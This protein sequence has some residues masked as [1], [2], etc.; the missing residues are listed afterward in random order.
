MRRTAAAA[1]LASLLTGMSDPAVCAHAQTAVPFQ[2]VESAPTPARS[3][4]LGNATVLAGLV[5][6][7]ASFP[8]ATQS[9]RRYEE[10]LAESDPTA[11]ES[12]WGAAQR[13]DR[14]ATTSLLAGEALLAAGVYLRFL[15]RSPDS[16]LRFAASASRCAVTLRF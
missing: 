10:Y 9:D 2:P 12:R 7:G 1:L 13:A 16:K 6:I 5:L 14:R 15:R 3:H 11:I 4:V 8:L